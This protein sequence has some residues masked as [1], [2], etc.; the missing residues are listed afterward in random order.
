MEARFDLKLEILESRIEAKL[1]ALEGKQSAMEAR[2]LDKMNDQTKTMFR[3]V[4]VTNA[5]MVFAVAGLAF[6]AARLA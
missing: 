1:H 2:L 5:T 4:V 6:G 3:T